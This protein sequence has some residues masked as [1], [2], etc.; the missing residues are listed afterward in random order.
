MMRWVYACVVWLVQPFLRAKLRRRAVAEPG[1]GEAMDERFGYYTQPAEP[2][3]SPQ[4]ANVG[5]FGTVVSPA[6]NRFIWVHAVSLGEARAAAVLVAQLRLQYPGMRLLLTH[7]TATGRALGKALLQSGDV[8]VWQPW[9]TVGAVTR[10]V[11]HFRPRMGL[12]IETEV[13]PNMVATFK[14]LQVP[15]CL[16][17]ARLSD[18]SLRQA[19]RLGALSKPAFAGLHAVWAQTPED[20]ARLQQLGAPVLGSL[21]NFKFDATPEAAQ[22]K[23]GAAW[24]GAQSKPVVMFASSRE[25]EERMLIDVLR[26]PLQADSQAVMALTFQTKFES[27]WPLAPVHNAQEAIKNIA[28]DVQWLIVPRHPQRFDEVACLFAEAGFNVSRRSAWG[29]SPAVADVWVGDSL[30]EMALYFGLAD[31][32]LLG[33]SFAPLG[34]QNLIE[35]AACGCP[36]VMGPHTFNFA[37]AAE[38]SVEGGA[39]FVVPD[40]ATAVDQARALVQSAAHLALARAA[41]LALNHAHRGAAERTAM[42]IHQLLG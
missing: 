30:G 41:A 20:A 39:A 38:L 6:A 29:D 7:G 4:T 16:V 2:R 10:F 37:Q 21:G 32:A 27:N 14:R 42:A 23:Q 22:L 35:A 12:L 11:Q 5:K 31:V 40:I 25:G 26:A 1:Y 36:V 9:D 34:G 28:S 3:E 24:R 15:L 19:L 17:N 8:Q 18:K 33:G 13:W